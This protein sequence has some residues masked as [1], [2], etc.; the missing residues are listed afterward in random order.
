MRI[1]QFFKSILTV[2]AKDRYKLFFTALGF[3]LIIGGYT[4]IRTVK[5]TLF[6]SIVGREYI[7]LAKIWSII[8][9]VPCVLL[10]SKLVDVVK[11]Y[12]LIYIYSF[13]FGVGGLIIAGLLQ[14]PMAWTDLTE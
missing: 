8:M 11:R 2:D 3:M 6:L 12:Q 13:I 4:V 1:S 5:D 7:P 10:F 9:L 14:H